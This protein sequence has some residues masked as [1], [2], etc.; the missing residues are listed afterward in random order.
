ME[1]HHIFGG[2]NRKK[3]EKYGLKVGALRRH[4]PPNGREAAHQ[5]AA[6][7]PPASPVWSEEVYERAGGHGR[8]V[9]GHVRKKLSLSGGVDMKD[10]R[11][12]YMKNRALIN[13]CGLHDFAW[14]ERMA[15][16]IK[17][18]EGAG[19]ENRGIRTVLPVDGKVPV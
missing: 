6:T 15:A 8:A 1:E 18:R 4:L 11:R 14:K 2:S 16:A 17:R 3:S 13:S 9:P 7:A 10:G 19:T 12:E 5:C